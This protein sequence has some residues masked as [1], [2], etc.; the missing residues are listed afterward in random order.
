MSV[1]RVGKSLPSNQVNVISNPGQGDNKFI[2]VY[3]LVKMM[4]WRAV[5]SCIFTVQYCRLEKK[6][7][8]CVLTGMHC[9]SFPTYSEN[10]TANTARLG[11]ILTKVYK[12]KLKCL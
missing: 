11:I 4:P 2:V 9:F 12:N 8:H 5:L 3:T 1:A 6:D 10:T 7:M